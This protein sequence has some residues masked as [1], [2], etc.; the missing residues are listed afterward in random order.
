MTGWVDCIEGIWCCCCGIKYAHV[1]TI[2]IVHKWLLWQSLLNKFDVV[3]YNSSHNH[4]GMV[5]LMSLTL[6]AISVRLSS[7][8]I[9]IAC[10]W[11]S[12]TLSGLIV[13]VHLWPMPVVSGISCTVHSKGVTC[14]TSE[15]CLTDSLL[16]L[17]HTST[18]AFPSLLVTL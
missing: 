5:S 1:F 16:W 18:L 13:S 11:R 9:S 15:T 6:P 10:H 7:N 2:M 12:V 17:S 14:F 3:A 8:A 4:V